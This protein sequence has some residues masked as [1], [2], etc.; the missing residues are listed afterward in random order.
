MVEA[1][2]VLADYGFLA[3]PR[4]RQKAYDWGGFWPGLLQGWQPN[5]PGQAVAMFFTYGFLHGGP[6]HLVVNMVTLWSLGYAVL[7]RVGALGFAGL[8]GASLL[9]GAAGFGLIAETF[10]PMVGASGALFGL[11]GGL[12]AWNYVDRFTF[13]EGLWPV[14]R[15]VLFLVAMNVAMWWALDGQLAWETH[16]GGFLV[17]WIMALLIDPRSRASV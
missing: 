13:R 5:Y 1:I 10:R 12:L 15:V 11:A 8:Y 2:L 9:G 17:G 4:L 16:L 7:D 6:L 3:D 14:A